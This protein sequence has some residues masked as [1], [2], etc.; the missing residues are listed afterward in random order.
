V[1]ADAA[2]LHPPNV[3]ADKRDANELDT[4]ALL[5]TYSATTAGNE[6]DENRE[7]SFRKRAHQ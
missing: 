7:H 2:A 1:C 6:A 5:V 3:L 4:A